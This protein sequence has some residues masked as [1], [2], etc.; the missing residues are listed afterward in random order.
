MTQQEFNEQVAA[1]IRRLVEQ[2]EARAAEKAK[3][4]DA[5]ETVCKTGCTCGA[6]M[7]IKAARD[8]IAE[9][10]AWQDSSLEVERQW[11]VQ[12]VGA[13]IGADIGSEIRPQ[14]LPAI[15]RLK[16]HIAELEDE[17]KIA[18]KREM[19]CEE[20]IAGPISCLRTE[21]WG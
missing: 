19:T 1:A 3:A 18:E 9:L 20:R 10:E 15:A 8:R 12:A 13:A 2:G 6:A 17:V 4:K 7:A 21:N 11:N 16:A 14:I 5:G